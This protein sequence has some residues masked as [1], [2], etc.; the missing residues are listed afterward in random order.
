[1]KNV[2][3]PVLVIAGIAVTAYFVSKPEAPEEDVAVKLPVAKGEADEVAGFI[4]AAARELGAGKVR[5][6]QGGVFVDVDG[7]T[8]GFV[9]QPDGSVAMQVEVDQ[10][11]RNGKA[12]RAP[13]L[14]AL[15]SKGD[16]IF[17]HARSLQARTAAEGA[18]ASRGVVAHGDG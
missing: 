9:K 4:A 14:Q 1:M 11:Y 2:I 17:T 8:I 10:K 5:A 6:Y 7:D 18:Y 3:A 12:E 13:A 15:K 16:A